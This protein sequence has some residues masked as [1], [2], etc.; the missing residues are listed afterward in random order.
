MNYLNLSALTSYI[1]LFLSLRLYT[2]NWS[3]RYGNYCTEPFGIL[4]LLVLVIHTN[5]N[6]KPCAVQLIGLC[7]NFLQHFNIFIV[8]ALIGDQHV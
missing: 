5:T 1:N 2:G 7:C 6:S 8:V 4:M 3:H